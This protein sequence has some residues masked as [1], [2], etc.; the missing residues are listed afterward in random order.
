MDLPIIGHSPLSRDQR[1]A[2]HLTAKHPLPAGFWAAT[3]KQI[4][5]QLLKVE[6]AKQLVDRR[7]A[8]VSLSVLIFGASHG[9]RESPYQFWQESYKA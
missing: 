5:F 9:G 2:N 4:V 1:L 7:I 6:N 3:T 8:C